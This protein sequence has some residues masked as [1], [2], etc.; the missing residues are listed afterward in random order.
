M[1][2][3]L[4]PRW[5]EPQQL[6]RNFVSAPM[7]CRSQSPSTD[8]RRWTRHGANKSSKVNALRP[9]P[10]ANMLDIVALRSAVANQRTVDGSDEEPL[11]AAVWFPC[12]NDYRTKHTRWLVGAWVACSS[13]CFAR[14][15]RRG[16]APVKALFRLFSF[17]SSAAATGVHSRADR[18]LP[19]SDDVGPVGFQPEETEVTAVTWTISVM[20]FGFLLMNMSLLYLVHVQDE[21]IRSYIY[22]IISVTI[23]IFCSVL[24]NQAAFSFFLQGFLP[25]PFPIGLGL[26]VGF[27]A[28][29]AVG[30]TFFVVSF[31]SITLLCVKFRYRQD[32]LYAVK[33]IV[34]H[35]NAFAGIFTFGEIQQELPFKKSLSMCFSIL[36]VAQ[37][38]LLTCRCV[39]DA[40]RRK[41]FAALSAAALAAKTYQRAEEDL[42]LRSESAPPMH[43]WVAEAEEAEDEAA[44][45]ILSFLAIQCVCFCVAGQL[46]T[47]EGEEPVYIQWEVQALFFVAMLFLVILLAATWI[48]ASRKAQGYMKRM[49]KNGHNFISMSMC[50]CLQRMTEWQMELWLKDEKHLAGVLAAFAT[51][52][53]SVLIILVLDAIADRLRDLNVEAPVD[54]SADAVSNAGSHTGGGRVSTPVTTRSR[55]TRASRGTATGRRG[56]LFTN[57]SVQDV[58]D[59]RQWEKAIRTIIAGFGLLVGLSWDKAFDVA[60]ITIVEG[61]PL[62]SKNPVSSRILIAIALVCFVL[63]AWLKFIVPMAVKD[64][65]ELKECIEL[66]IEAQRRRDESYERTLESSHPRTPPRTPKYFSR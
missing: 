61:M 40:V 29:L 15:T 53:L 55:S 8:K 43:N 3:F 19:R 13:A 27:W 63:P 12:G 2:S 48:R 60:D 25:S 14:P 51:T 52:V 47:M 39:S 45:L 65:A 28:K 5:C 49:T 1:A 57:F 54:A 46:P 20:L 10:L 37:V 23:S 42:P 66:E 58:R 9:S 33:T 62:L 59:Q 44:V 18:L 11:A 50:W 36:L 22:N 24:L 7:P 34:A 32:L 41:G 31:T 56:R 21:N 38:L 30:V 6:N 35:L 16:N 4:M 17:V 64:E 26:E